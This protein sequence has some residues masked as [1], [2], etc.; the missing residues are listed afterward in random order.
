[1][2]LSRITIRFGHKIFFFSREDNPSVPNKQDSP[3]PEP[4]PSWLHFAVNHKRPTSSSVALFVE[5]VI[6]SESF[7]DC[8]LCE[9][10][11]VVFVLVVIHCFVSFSL[12]RVY[13][14]TILI[15]TQESLAHV[16]SIVIFYCIPFFS[17]RDCQ[18]RE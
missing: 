17:I 10:L 15:A 6:V 4:F 14:H 12:L 13:Y 11:L 3:L 8:C 9:I 2:K 16:V 18:Q 1:M 5:R 7:F